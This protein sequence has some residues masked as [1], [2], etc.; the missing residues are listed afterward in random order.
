MAG[1]IWTSGLFPLRSD[2]F[3]FPMI[4][5]QVFNENNEEQALCYQVWLGML[6]DVLHRVQQ[7][8]DLAM[9]SR[10]V[11]LYFTSC[12]GLFHNF[13]SVCLE[14]RSI[15]NEAMPIPDHKR[16]RRQWKYDKSCLYLPLSRFC[17]IDVL[18]FSSYLKQD[19]IAL[20]EWLHSRVEN[21]LWFRILFTK[22]M[23]CLGFKHILKVGIFASYLLGWSI[24][25][26]VKK[27][28][29]LLGPHY[30]FMFVLDLQQPLDC[31]KSFH[32]CLYY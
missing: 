32:S 19:H 29:Y 18:K 30:C 15:W 27:M 5:F 4:W 1:K 17:H 28:A 21:V 26:F 11:G 10:S 22:C 14:L 24:W 2:I 23:L 9:Y 7:L 12:V 13:S 31:C 20:G 8:L 3:I 16:Q 6:Q 25:N